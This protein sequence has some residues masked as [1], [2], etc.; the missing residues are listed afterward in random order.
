MAITQVI[1]TLPAAPDPAT[2]TRDEFSAAAAAYVLAQKDMVPELNTWAGEVNAIAATAVGDVATAIGAAGADTPVDADKF[3]FRKAADGLLKSIT[4]SGLK[5]IFASLAGSAT[6]VFSVEAA[7]ADDH[8]VS[9]VFGDARYAALAGSASQAF[10]TNALTASGGVSSISATAL[11]GYGT[12]AGGMVTQGTNKSTAV[13]LNKPS[14]EITMNNASLAAGA[15]ASFILNNTVL[16]SGAV[17]IVNPVWAANA[18]EC[19]T[20]N[21]TGAAVL[22]TLKNIT[23]GSLSDAVVIRFAVIN[24]ATA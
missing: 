11:I 20:R 6:Q 5:G 13:T 12:G 8:A 21:T 16:A 9:R 23:A 14:G 7:T 17:V 18:Y 1:T 2:M 4:L 24:C 10:A 3:T 19:T 15:S 22:I